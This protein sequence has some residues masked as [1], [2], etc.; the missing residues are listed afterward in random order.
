MEGRSTEGPILSFGPQDLVGITTPQNDALVIRATID[1][2]DVAQI[3]I[4]VGSSV[5]IIF[6]EAFDHMQMDLAKLKPVSTS[7]FDFLRNKVPPLRQVNLTLSLGLP[8]T[9]LNMKHSSLV[10][11]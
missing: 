4:N 5:N 3:F 11:E 1:D 9:T 6:K 10:F 8:I 7:L 2:Y